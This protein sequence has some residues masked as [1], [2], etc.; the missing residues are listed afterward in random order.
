MKYVY[1][2]HKLTTTDSMNTDRAFQWSRDCNAEDFGV[3]CLSSYKKASN[4]ITEAGAIRI[5]MTRV[6]RPRKRTSFI[7]KD[8]TGSVSLV[9]F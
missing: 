2:L 8:V 7:L 6:T 5:E 1:F 4:E 9:T 3:L